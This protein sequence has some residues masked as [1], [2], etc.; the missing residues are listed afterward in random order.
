MQSIVLGTSSTKP[1]IQAITSGE[2]SLQHA[3]VVRNIVSTAFFLFMANLNR[4]V[5]RNL[6]S[7]HQVMNGSFDKLRLCCTYGA[8]GVVS[9]T[10]EELIIESAADIE[11]PW[12]EYHFKVKPGDVHRR[13]R[14]ISPYHHRIDWQMW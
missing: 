9:E 6:F 3:P 7:K 1:Y 8:F 10:R 14:W 13:P 2:M 4:N 12:R 11:G 5:V